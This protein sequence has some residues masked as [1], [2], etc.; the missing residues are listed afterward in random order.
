MNTHTIQFIEIVKNNHP[1]ANYL[2]KAATWNYRGYTSYNGRNVFPFSNRRKRLQ[3]AHKHLSFDY[4]KDKLM[5]K[6][7]LGF[8]WSL[9][10]IKL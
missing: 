7:K 3:C 2:I 4:N 9:R 5:S 8:G 10:S 1:T 6:G